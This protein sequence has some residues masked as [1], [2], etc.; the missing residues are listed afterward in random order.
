MNHQALNA[1]CARGL[2]CGHACLSIVSISPR[3]RAHAARARPAAAE[4]VREASPA[5]WGPSTLSTHGNLP[6]G[7]S[8]GGDPCAP[9]VPVSSP[10][11]GRGTAGHTPTWYRVSAKCQLGVEGPFFFFF[12]FLKKKEKNTKKACP[13][14]SESE[15]SAGQFHS[16]ENCKGK[17]DPLYSP[18]NPTISISNQADDPLN[19]SI[20]LSGGKET[21]RDSLSNGE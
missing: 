21:N 2:S 17:G 11:A 16:R 8:L 20:L 13:P 6:G 14:A 4:T 18:R 7:A 12:F 5:G 10:D 1:Y 15:P 3:L 9:P 19:L